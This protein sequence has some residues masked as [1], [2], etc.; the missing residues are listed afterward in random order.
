MS[1]EVNILAVD[2]VAQNLTAL[3]ALL[4]RPGLRILKAASADEA[5]EWLLREDVALALID[6]QMP[7]TDGFQLAEL[8]RGSERTRRIPLIFLTAAARDPQRTFR[9]YEAG[10]V[11]FLHKPLDATILKS[12]VDVFVE[13]YLQKR[14]LSEQLR[15][16]EEALR[17]NEV[18]A[19]V[20]GHDLRNPLA[21]V[22]TS[23]EVLLRLNGGPQVTAAAERIRSSTKRMTRMINQLLDVAR[24]RAGRFELNLQ[25]ADLAEVCLAIGDEVETGRGE[26]RVRIDTRG[27]TWGDFDV[28]RMSQV[29]SNLIG[30]A[31]QHGDPAQPIVVTIDG[32]EPARIRVSVANGGHVPADVL[33]HIFEPF[34]S[35]NDAPDRTTTSKGLG[36]GL[37]IVE[38]FVAAHRGSVRA[39]SEPATGTMLEFFLPR[40]ALSRASA[41]GAPA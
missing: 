15:T 20:L 32:S 34:H 1:L 37:H 14:Q 36:L 13:L 29:L 31:L 12:K 23:A 21:A 28:D 17:M 30:N 35:P 19:A 9:G 6:V 18:F 41:P 8:V 16:L 38:R 24:I 3:E 5:L 26:R 39:H 7:H 10:A 22:A 40:E 4:A 25:R 27:D 11:D 33:A 2:D